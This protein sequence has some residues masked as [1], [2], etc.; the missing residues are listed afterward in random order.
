MK[1]ALILVDI[2]NDYFPGGRSEL[3]G[4]EAAAAA[5][6]KI[7]RIFRVHEWPV[8][9][10]RHISQDEGAS[11]FL[12]DT[13][14]SETAKVVS[15][16]PNEEVFIKHAPNSFI[17]TPLGA[18]LT[19]LGV[20]R[21]VIAGMMSHMCIDSTTRA[22]G[23]LGYEVLLVHDA[24]ATKALAFGGEVI[25]AMQVHTAFM[26][27]LRAFARVVSLEELKELL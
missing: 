8:F 2:Q 4:A 16:L 22:A 25:P 26:A 20:E 9:H 3:C 13:P 27:A 11:F 5:A 10:I 24:C 17:G 12:P 1:T 15:P 7:L 14:G 19:S 6:R 21:V 23:E 18:A